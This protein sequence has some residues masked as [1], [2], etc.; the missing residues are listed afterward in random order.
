MARREQLE[1]MREDDPNDPFL[2]FALAQ[3]WVKEE[4]FEEAFAALEETLRLDP[5]YV[6]AHQHKAQLLIRLGRP[7]EARPVLEA[8]MS[9]AAE[10]GDHHAQAEL[11]QMLDCLGPA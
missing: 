10:I 6:A 4:R 3:E 9:A 5:Q 7:A 8:G 2:T 1:R 11:K